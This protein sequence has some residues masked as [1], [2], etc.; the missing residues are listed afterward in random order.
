MERSMKG[1]WIVSSLLIVALV[2]IA[3]LIAYTI[4]AGAAA[5][6]GSGFR[7]EINAGDAF[8][9][10]AEEQESLEVGEAAVLIVEDRAGDIR[11]LVGEAG[12]IQ[13]A[14]HKVA[15]GDSQAEAD[16]DLAAL[17]FQISQEGSTVTVAVIQPEAAI[18]MGMCRADTVD[19]TIR[20]PE[21]TAVRASTDSGEVS[22][23]GTGGSASLSS[24]YGDILASQVVGDLQAETSS[25][26]VE[27]RDIRNGNVNLH[28]DYGDVSLE[29]AGVGSLT[30]TTS[31]GRITL[32]DVRASGAVALDDDYGDVTF[33]GGAA[34]SLDVETG[35]GRVSLSSLTVNGGL[36]AHSD[37]GDVTV[38][39]VEAG[40]YELSSSSGD[41]TADGVNDR[42]RIRSDY[43]RILVR[44]AE[45]ADLDL[46]T[47][48]GEVT[49]EGSLGAGPHTLHSDYGSILLMIP[50]GTALSFDLQTDYGGI[51][52]E[53]PV[54]VTGEI[55]ED[56]WVGTTD[57]GGIVLSAS[58]NSGDIRIE[59]L[60]P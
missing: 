30:I 28:S 36:T 13:V 39:G 20:V 10:E 21:G 55:D 32:T 46:D 49:F 26:R 57:G 53:I 12:E 14:A 38:T 1:K 54:S 40:S 19:F 60:N 29:D 17:D 48:S 24:A 9:A 44:N 45:Q 7:L 43:G 50:A 47:S 25:G 15:H 56:H 42:V 27:A 23:T 4:I 59:V 18:C 6:R 37:Y 34:A 58:T 8:T 2:G 11:V 31:S 5:I 33:E 52:S 16:A 51:A 41:V 22:V 3:V 35:S